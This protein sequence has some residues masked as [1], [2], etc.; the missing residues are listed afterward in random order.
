MEVFL[1]FKVQEGFEWLTLE[2]S[3]V[4]HRN[5]GTACDNFFNK[6]KNENIT[7]D[8]E[9]SDK[10]WKEKDLYPVIYKII[11]HSTDD[12]RLFTF[13]QEKAIESDLVFLHR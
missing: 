3:M 6:I 11:I 8:F 1:G 2:T 13:L 10:C 7:H 9:M 4:V 5:F 12:E